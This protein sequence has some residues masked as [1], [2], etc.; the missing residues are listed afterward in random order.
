MK[1][2]IAM[3]AFSVASHT[4]RGIIVPPP[5]SIFELKYPDDDVIGSAR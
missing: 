2:Y 4:D 5:G 1:E 3:R